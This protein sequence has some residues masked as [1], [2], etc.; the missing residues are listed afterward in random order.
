MIARRALLLLLGG[1]AAAYP[2]AA[3]AQQARPAPVVGLVSIGASAADAGNFRAFLEQMRELGHVDGT[4]IIFDKRFAGGRDELIEEYVAALVRRPVDI[5]VVTGA[6]E[7]LA[8]RQATS[9][10]PIVT[11][12]I[13]DPIGMGLAQSLA[14]P[15]GNV[16]GLT[17]MDLDIYGKRL[18]LLKEAVPGLRKAAM[19]VSPGNPIYRRGSPWA[20][21]VEADARSL[22]LTLD[23]IEAD[24][25]NFDGALST[26]AAAG[27]Q[28]LVVSSDG[29]F[30]AHRNELA[31]ST[32]KHRLPAIFAFRPQAEVGGLMAYAARVEDLSRRAAFFVDRIL[33]GAKPADLPIEQPT[34][35]TLVI[36]LRTAKLFGLDLP[37]VL[38][39]Q[40]DE[41]IE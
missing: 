20:S 28:G 3:H 4:N 41:V 38:L 21:A 34:R 30:L 35:F 15:G 24:E 36:N 16:T 7:S 39:A 29:I 22:G 33:K 31:E 1:A 40:A 12:V 18:E 11:I 13:P 23:L 25:T 37:A 26:L 14:R 19:L 32:I 5:I 9:S 10:I 27:V 17:T 8:A 6:R 2:N